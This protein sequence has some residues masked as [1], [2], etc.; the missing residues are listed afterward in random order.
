MSV[1]NFALFLLCAFTCYQ[2]S[3]ADEYCD[4]CRDEFKR[5]MQEI[6]ENDEIPECIKSYAP[7]MNPEDSH[8]TKRRKL[9]EHY[10]NFKRMVSAM[11]KEEK[12]EMAEKITVCFEDFLDVVK[13]KMVDPSYEEC[14]HFFLLCG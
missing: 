4:E 1:T 13:S 6:K 3:A 12:I 8:E 10:S 2:Y 5:A 11:T 9:K 14:K 7:K